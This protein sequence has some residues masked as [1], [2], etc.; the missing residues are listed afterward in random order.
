MDYQETGL[1]D[2]QLFREAFAAGWAKYTD[3]HGGDGAAASRE[4]RR[5]PVAF[6]R[7]IFGHGGDCR[8]LATAA[9]LAGPSLFCASPAAGLHDSLREFSAEVRATDNCPPE[10][11]GRVIPRLSADARLF[12]QVTSIMH[13]EHLARQRDSASPR[14]YAEALDLYS[15]ARGFTDAYRLDT[16]FEIAAMK[17]TTILEG[18]SHLWAQ[19][20][21]MPAGGRLA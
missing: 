17:V 2:K 10:L 21:F 18:K 13:L 15:A 16:R 7:M 4:Y 8:Q 11:L 19:V 5:G 3:L 1:P 20:P 14:D 6:A 9:C 12:F